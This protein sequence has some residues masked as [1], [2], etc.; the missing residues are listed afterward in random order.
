MVRGGHGLNGTVPGKTPKLELG[1]MRFD[2]RWGHA[3]VVLAY[4]VACKANW[5]VVVLLC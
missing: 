5:T 1:C 2:T 3:A 4:E